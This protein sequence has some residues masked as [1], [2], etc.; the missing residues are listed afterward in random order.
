L[1]GWL[2]NVWKKFSA[3]KEDD[4][5]DNPAALKKFRDET[6]VAVEAA[7]EMSMKPVER[8]VSQTQGAG[9]SPRDPVPMPKSF[10]FFPNPVLQRAPRKVDHFG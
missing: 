3:V 7:N 10:E 6:A 1:H 2:D 9:Q 5:K 8:P 4:L